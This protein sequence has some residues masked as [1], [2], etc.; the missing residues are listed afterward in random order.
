MFRQDRRAHLS[1]CGLQGFPT[2]PSVRHSTDSHDAAGTPIAGR[3]SLT[4]LPNADYLA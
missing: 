3:I 4:G 2:L 1:P